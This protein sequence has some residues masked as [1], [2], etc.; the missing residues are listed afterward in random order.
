MFEVLIAASLVAVV[1]VALGRRQETSPPLASDG[2]ETDLP[3]P[4]CLGPTDE[5]D[6]ACMTCGQSF[7]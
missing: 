6:H 3:C 7:G 1:M 5:A 2:K 4:W